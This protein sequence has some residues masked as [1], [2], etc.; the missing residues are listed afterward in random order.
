M[1]HWKSRWVETLPHSPR[2]KAR[3]WASGEQPSRYNPQLMSS[4]AP[5]L[6]L[7]MALAGC[8]NIGATNPSLVVSRPEAP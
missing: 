6:E 8:A 5:E 7:Q 4:T 2:P 1:R 3:P